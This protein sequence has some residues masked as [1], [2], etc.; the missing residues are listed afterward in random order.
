MREEI[1]IAA[2]FKSLV[3]AP[4]D[5]A[6]EALLFRVVFVGEAVDD[7]AELA[8]RMARKLLSYADTVLIGHYSSQR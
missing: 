2:I 4:V 7:K 5:V 3:C 6:H 8:A 1:N